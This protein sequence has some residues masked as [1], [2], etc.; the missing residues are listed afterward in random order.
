MLSAEVFQSMSR[1]LRK[2]LL[3]LFFNEKKI[4]FPPQQ[5]A[6]CSFCVCKGLDENHG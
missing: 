4:C 2:D 5:V 3:L 6:R 1:G